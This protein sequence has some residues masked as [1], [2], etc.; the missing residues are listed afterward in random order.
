MSHT[1]YIGGAES[2]GSTNRGGGTS[3]PNQGWAMCKYTFD[4]KTTE[5]IETKTVL[6]L[7]LVYKPETNLDRLFIKC[8]KVYGPYLESPPCIIKRNERT[9]E[10]GGPEGGQVHPAG[11]AG[12]PAS[13]FGSSFG[14]TKTTTR[15][16]FIEC[17]EMADDCEE[18]E[19]KVENVAWDDLTGGPLAFG[20]DEQDALT[21]A[22]GNDWTNFEFLLRSL[23]D[24]GHA[25]REGECNLPVP[26]GWTDKPNSMPTNLGDLKCGTSYDGPMPPLV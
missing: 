15:T 9:S 26:K 23:D 19:Y 3:T 18:C 25:E 1:N 16:W 2:A 10:T 14:M 5:T 20:L 17:Y 22:N 7:G 13:L 21:Q 8:E 4:M 11:W 6:G 12:T 24:N